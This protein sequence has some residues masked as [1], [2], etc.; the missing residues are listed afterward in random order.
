MLWTTDADAT[1]NPVYFGRRYLWND[2][3]NLGLDPPQGWQ[4]LIRTGYLVERNPVPGDADNDGIVHEIDASILAS[5]WA[6]A[7]DWT[8]GDFN[9]DGVVNAADASIM[10]ANWGYGTSEAGAVPEPSAFV[11]L[12]VGVLGLLTRDRQRRRT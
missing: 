2:L 12:S 1:V 3:P 5:H 11:L 8:D 6:Q 9:G 10:A 4:D 7:G